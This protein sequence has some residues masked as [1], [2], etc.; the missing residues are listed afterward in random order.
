MVVSRCLARDNT[1]VIHLVD[2]FLGELLKRQLQKKFR[3][4]TSSY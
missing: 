4:S 3:K 2:I 1:L